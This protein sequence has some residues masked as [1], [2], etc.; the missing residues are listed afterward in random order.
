[1]AW[2]RNPRNSGLSISKKGSDGF[3]RSNLSVLQELVSS[4]RRAS[5]FSKFPKGDSTLLASSSREHERGIFA[6]RDV[7]WSDCCSK[8]LL[9]ETGEGGLWGRA[10]ASGSAAVVPD[11]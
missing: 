10:R 3:S 7:E 5:I 1:M 4:S 8:S 2:L 6:P 9:L 11:R